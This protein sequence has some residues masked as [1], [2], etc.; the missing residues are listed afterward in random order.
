MQPPVIAGVPR[1]TAPPMP[2]WT[3]EFVAAATAELHG[4][5]PVLGAAIDAIGPCTLLP[6]QRHFALLVRI[7]ISQQISVRAA[8]SVAQR[9]RRSLP[10][11]R[12]TP[13]GLARLTV[14]EI[15]AAG[16][17]SARA[18]AVK[19]LAEEVVAKRIR[20]RDLGKVSDDETVASLTRH[21]G[22]G[23]WTAEMLLLFGHGRLDIFPEGDLGIRKAIGDLFGHAELPT[24]VLCRQVAESWRPYRSVAAWYLWR[25]AD[26]T[27]ATLGLSRYPV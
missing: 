19:N 1:R 24:P 11:R 9:L 2:A 10:S 16:L 22:I 14:D 25:H 13:A 3:T 20:L 23:R 17:P 5:D 18:I 4:R 26:R 27:N 7:I 8:R 21:T 12:L 6:E 15:R